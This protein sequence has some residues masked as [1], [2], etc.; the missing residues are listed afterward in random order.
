MWEYL[1]RIGDTWMARHDSLALSGTSSNKSLSCSIALHR[2]CEVRSFACTVNPAFMARVAQML[3]GMHGSTHAHTCCLQGS[4]TLFGSVIK[5][6]KCTAK[7]DGPGALL[8]RS[9]EVGRLLLGVARLL[10]RLPEQRKLLKVRA[11]A[12]YAGGCCR[13]SKAGSICRLF[14]SVLIGP[15]VIARTH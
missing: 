10:A 12:C 8:Q 13:C 2:H 5:V 11:H 3:P 4:W 6:L 7:H 14:Y 1:S 9:G 15:H